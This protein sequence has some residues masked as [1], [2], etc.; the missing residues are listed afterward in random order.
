MTSYK[1]VINMYMYLICFFGCPLRIFP[2]KIFSYFFLG[3]VLYQSWSF[4][5]AKN[6]YFIQCVMV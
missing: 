2:F 1:L 3:K 5:M 6:M 4:S